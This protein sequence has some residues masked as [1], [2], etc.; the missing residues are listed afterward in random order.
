MHW[1]LAIVIMVMILGLSTTGYGESS[2]QTTYQRGAPKTGSYYSAKDYWAAKRKALKESRKKSR[3]SSTKKKTDEETDSSTKNTNTDNSTASDSKDGENDNLPD[4]DNPST[5]SA[6]PTLIVTEPPPQNYKGQSSTM[7]EFELSS[8]K[9]ILLKTIGASYAERG[10]T[11][12]TG[13]SQTGLVSYVFS[14]IGYPVEESSPE[15]MWNETGLFIDASLR[16]SRT[17]DILYFKLFSQKEGKSK[18]ALAIYLEDGV[19]VYPSFTTQKVI[20]RTCDNAFWR[21]R[22]VGSKRVLTGK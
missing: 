8:C 20:K 5:D 9:R 1:T 17:G 7:E 19:M 6:E 12:E 22:F 14:N 15:V 21:S 4:T 13:F 10:A 18:L 3:S 11:P 2:Y 16:Q